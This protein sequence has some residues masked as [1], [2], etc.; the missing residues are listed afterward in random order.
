[1]GN[2]A[3]LRASIFGMTAPPPVISIPV[4][5]TGRLVGAYNANCLGQR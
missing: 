4:S 2:L 5:K 3:G 1:L